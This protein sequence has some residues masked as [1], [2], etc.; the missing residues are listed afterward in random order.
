MEKIKYDLEEIKDEFELVDNIDESLW[1]T[2]TGEKITGDYDM[3]IRGTDHRALLDFYDL[4]RDDNKSWDMLHEAGYIRVVPETNIALVY[5]NQPI[6]AS[7]IEEIESNNYTFESY[8]VLEIDENINL[9]EEN[10]LEKLDNAFIGLLKNEV[11]EDYYQGM[12]DMTTI[13]NK[14][15][16]EREKNIENV[17]TMSKYL[18]KNNIKTVLDVKNDTLSTSDNKLSL[19][20]EDINNKPEKSLNRFQQTTIKKDKS[21]AIEL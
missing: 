21:I 7:Q 19:N 11:T 2:P 9:S 16:T 17:F 13:D 4:D 18:E 1:I 8:G 10:Q 6:T 5:E 14:T 3:G 12:K 15:R 20:F